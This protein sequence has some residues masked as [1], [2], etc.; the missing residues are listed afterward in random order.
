MKAF[1]LVFVYCGACAF[2]Q[3]AN[4]LMQQQMRQEQRYIDENTSAPPSFSVKQGKVPA[5]AMVRISCNTPRE[6]IYYTTNGWTPT[7]SSRRYTGPIPIKTTMVL[8]AFASM[9]G[10]M[11]SKIVR[12]TYT[13]IDTPPLIP[14]I[15]LGADGVLHAKTRLHL[16]TNST[17]DSK[18]A[19]AGDK[20][21]LFLNQD[22][23]AGD[24]IVVPKGTPLDATLTVATPSAIAGVTG[25]LAFE[26]HSLAVPGSTV[27]LHGGETLDGKD[28]T[29]IAG[30]MVLSIVASVPAI[31]VHGG[32]AEIKPGMKFTVAV[33][34]DTPLKLS[35]PEAKAKP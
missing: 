11:P 17:V 6:V 8:Q 24:K 15:V 2:G 35:A 3:N 12:A 14:P 7:A 27:P 4:E 26:V 5:G 16:V 1:L 28:R 31:F 29:A 32:Q 23:Q 33:A 25:E 30:V 18:T 10:L 20:L 34:A 19:K 13:V 21:R 22:I 9:P